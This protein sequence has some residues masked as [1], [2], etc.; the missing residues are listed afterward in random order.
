MADTVAYH[1]E[2]MLPELEDLEQRGL[3]SRDE[4]KE[5]ARQRRDFEY[6]LK[7]HSALKQDFL[8]Y[9]DYETQLETIRRARKKVLCESL[10]AKGE[11]WRN[12]IC[13]RSN[14]MRIMMIY[15]RAV[16]KFKGDLELW[17]RYA[18]F[19]RARGTRRVQKVMMK[20]IQLHPAVPGLWIYAAV[21]EAEHNSNVTAAR[22]LMQ[23]GI[24]SCPKSEILWHEYFRM[25]LIFAEKVKARRLVLGLASQEKPAIIE[26]GEVHEN[27]VSNS[28]T[29]VAATEEKP[30]VSHHTASCKIAQVIYR[31][32]IAEIPDNLQFRQR[33][34]EILETI[35]VEKLEALE[36]EIYAGMRKDFVT[37]ENSWAWLARRQYV[38]AESKG[39]DILECRKEATNVYEEGLQSVSSARM[40]ELYADFLINNLEHDDEQIEADQSS[41]GS[42]NLEKSAETLLTLYERAKVAGVESE[43]LAQ[44]QAG[45]LLRWGNVGS[46]IESLENSCKETASTCGSSRIWMQLFSIETK[47]SSVKNLQGSEQHMKLLKASLKMA[48]DD[49]KIL[50]QMAAEAQTVNRKQLDGFLQFLE[51]ILAGTIRKH[52]AAEVA[53]A[54]VDYVLHAEGLQRAREIYSR[55]IA[56]PSPGLNFLKSCIA[57]EAAS[58]VDGNAES[59]KQLRKLFNLG[60]ELY[61]HHDDGLWLEFC[62]QERKAGN[63]QEASNIYWRAKKALS[64]PSNF[65][66]KYQLLQ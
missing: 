66:E 22:S 51:S 27:G 60:V 17:L 28:E 42:Q 45:L 13:D 23:Q 16:T 38:K 9:V 44:G 57:I 6:L 62:A 5:I 56:L 64:N 25:E 41:D 31:N 39:M 21:W 61:G 12:S 24:R 35:D 53:A 37:D 15:E 50:L 36:E 4:I 63:I 65:L 54:L 49:V 47:L 43:A 33:F 48:N 2:R 26:A 34:L 52:A 10:K 29:D 55:L 14:A 3:F 19:C 7:R 58:V 1:M 11:S 20:A 46:A 30:R 18:E 32:A 59:L 8:R 40:Y